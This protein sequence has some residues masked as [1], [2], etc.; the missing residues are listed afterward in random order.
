MLKDLP[1]GER[2]EDSSKENRNIKNFLN[3]FGFGDKFLNKMKKFDRLEKNQKIY[4]RYLQCQLNDVSEL[5]VCFNKD[6]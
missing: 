5:I 3:K 2:L 1:P 6:L 4:N